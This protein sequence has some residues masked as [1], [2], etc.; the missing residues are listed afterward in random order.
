MTF[1]D[2]SWYSE[3]IKNL[4]GMIHGARGAHLPQPKIRIMST[5]S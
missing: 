4:S 3:I 2:K 5:T 1:F